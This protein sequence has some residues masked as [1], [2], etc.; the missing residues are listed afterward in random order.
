MG[1]PPPLEYYTHRTPQFLFVVKWGG[2]LDGMLSIEVLHTLNGRVVDG[3]ILSE[4]SLSSLH[5]RWPEKIF[6][7]TLSDSVRH[8]E[9]ADFVKNLNNAALLEAAAEP[10]V[11]ER[12]PDTFYTD[13]EDHQ[14]LIDIVRSAVVLSLLPQSRYT[15][16]AEV[17]PAPPIPCPELPAD[18]GAAITPEATSQFNK[19]YDIALDRVKG[20]DIASAMR[21]FRRAF[22][23]GGN[24]QDY[25]EVPAA[26]ATD[27][28]RFATECGVAYLMLAGY[29]LQEEQ[30]D[31]ALVSLVKYAEL[32]LDHGSRILQQV[33]NA[34]LLRLRASCD[35]R[36]AAAGVEPARK[37]LARA[38]TM[39][40]V[41]RRFFR[42]TL[43][44]Q[45][46]RMARH[47]RARGVGKKAS[48]D[49]YDMEHSTTSDRLNELLL[50]REAILDFHFTDEFFFLHKLR[51][52]IEGERPGPPNQQDVLA[53]LERYRTESRYE[54]LC[55][56]LKLAVSQ[57]LGDPARDARRGWE[58]S[59][60]QL[61]V[62]EIIRL[63]KN[64]GHPRKRVSA[65]W[66]VAQVEYLVSRACPRKCTHNGRS[67]PMDLAQIH[68]RGLLETE[69]DPDIRFCYQR[70]LVS[71]AEER[72]R[73][74][75][76]EVELDPKAP[77]EGVR[78]LRR[79]VAK[80][81]AEGGAASS[82]I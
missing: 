59:E 34:T 68:A 61:S 8:T 29:Q 35:D 16:G 51:A 5:V 39:R 41:C 54:E 22:E 10:S 4:D 25:A 82:L 74:V 20:R 6:D 81:I 45:F 65:F 44:P 67:C 79:D 78:Q 9:L 15:E 57:P 73:R 47:G 52:K 42:D 18:S 63:N 71:V 77:K 27:L 70:A 46:E 76:S 31:A 21:N 30:L 13:L 64:F 7:D 62:A 3:N 14:E 72:L 43:H 2:E 60:F 58:E 33:L 32:N 19:F 17:P 69:T 37:L 55:D 38:D 28:R 50:R 53:A 26:Y 80:R 48:S 1:L 56:A 12:L 40:N 36:G 66:Q 75:L 24:A 11:S 49:Y 23:H